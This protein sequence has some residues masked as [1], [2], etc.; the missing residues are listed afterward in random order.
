M[1]CFID[2]RHRILNQIHQ[3][4]AIRIDIVDTL[5]VK[6]CFRYDFYLFYYFLMFLLLLIIYYHL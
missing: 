3:P 5:K 6:F 2:C 1:L 4:E